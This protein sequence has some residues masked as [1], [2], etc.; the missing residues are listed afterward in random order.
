MWFINL[1]KRIFWF[2]Q[3]EYRN[4]FDRT[5]HTCGRHEVQDCWAWGRWEVVSDG[6]TRSKVMAKTYNI[7]SDRL[8]KILTEAVDEKITKFKSAFT[9]ND[10][11][12][13]SETDFEIP[14]VG[15]GVSIQES[16][17]DLILNYDQKNPIIQ[18]NPPMGNSST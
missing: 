4:P 13:N 14:I 5:C 7:P 10:G 17:G 2:H 15:Y 18:K 9:W 3:W 6:D 11:E 8:T 16:I 12:L 1:L